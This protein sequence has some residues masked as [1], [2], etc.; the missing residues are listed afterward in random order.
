MMLRMKF[1]WDDA[2]HERNVRERGF[3][4]D[5]AAEIFRGDRIEWVDERRDYG[6]VRIRAVGLI[7]I[8]LYHVVYTIRGD[9]RWIISARRASRKERRLWQSER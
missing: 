7:G 8:N 5:V 6:E 1:G 3:G 9:L 2:K 4:F